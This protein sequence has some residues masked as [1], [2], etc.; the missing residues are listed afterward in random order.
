[1]DNYKKKIKIL[2]IIKLKNL[3]EKNLLIRELS[4][5]IEEARK[6]DDQIFN[7]EKSIFLLLDHFFKNQSQELASLYPVNRLLL[8]GK[9]IKNESL[10][11]KLWLKI[12]VIMNKIKKNDNSLDDVML[13]MRSFLNQKINSQEK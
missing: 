5:L 9:I 2:K 11:N 7:D 13:E 1:M 10:L 3:V 4:L 12:Y 6:L 8:K